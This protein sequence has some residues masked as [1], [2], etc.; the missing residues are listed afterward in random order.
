MK[1]SRYFDDGCEVMVTDEAA[2]A[3]ACQEQ[4][5]PYIVLLQEHNRDESFPM[6]AYCVE[7]PE[8]CKS[9]LREFTGSDEMVKEVKE[10]SEL[11]DMIVTATVNSVLLQSRAG[12]QQEPEDPFDIV[13]KDDFMSKQ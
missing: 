11:K 12:S 2:V 6:G 1:E 8:E 4:Q 10:L 7:N 3:F 13:Y 9:V 5:I